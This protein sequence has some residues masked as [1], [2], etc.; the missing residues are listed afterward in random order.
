MTLFSRA[1]GGVLFAMLALLGGCASFTPD[2]GFTAVEQAGAQLLVTEPLECWLKGIDAL[3]DLG[4]LFDQ[5]V[6][7]A[8]ENFFE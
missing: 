7:A 1:K 6:I 2:G 8:A 4:I 5:P 3:D